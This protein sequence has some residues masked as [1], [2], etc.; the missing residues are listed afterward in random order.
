[1]KTKFKL[2][3]TSVVTLVSSASL[4]TTFTYAWINANRDIDQIMLVAGKAEAR[5]N[6]YMFKRQN[7]GLSTYVNNTPNKNA[8]QISSS[9]NQL[10]FSFADTI[11]SLFSDFDYA[12]LYYDE[13]SLNASAIPSY[14]VELQVQTIVEQSYIRVRLWDEGYDEADVPD[15]TDFGYRFHIASNNL[16]SPIEYATPSSVSLLA[17]KSLNDLNHSN[18]MSI[19]DNATDYMQITIPPTQT[20]FYDTHFA[21]SVIIEITPK[22]LSLFRFLQE[23]NGLV[24]TQ[25]MLGTRLLITFE[26]LLVPFGTSS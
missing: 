19:S 20:A 3:L 5:V 6:G 12:D 7:T 26:Y 9:E 10:R 4:L 15:F 18:A 11:G 23:T 16:T 25:Q 24:N 13:N 8:Q 1:M 14:F 22:P 2:I 21:R 17:S